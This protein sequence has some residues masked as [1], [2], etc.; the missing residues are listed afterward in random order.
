MPLRKKKH[1]TQP[2]FK[3]VIIVLL[4]TVNLSNFRTQNGLSIQ[5]I[6]ATSFVEKWIETFVADEFS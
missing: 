2:T 3:L 4:L 1:N 6:K 5:L